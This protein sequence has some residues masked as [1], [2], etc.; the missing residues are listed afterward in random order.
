VPRPPVVDSTIR[1][2]DSGHLTGNGEAGYLQK[3]SGDNV[4]KGNSGTQIQHRDLAQTCT[5]SSIG[6]FHYRNL[7]M[8]T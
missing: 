3:V 5:I 2:E 8:R 7:N 6:N 4:V 1:N